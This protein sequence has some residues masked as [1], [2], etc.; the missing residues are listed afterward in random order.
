MGINSLTTWTSLKQNFHANIS[1]NY[2]NYG[3]SFYKHFYLVNGTSYQIGE[4]QDF[5]VNWGFLGK[6]G[7]RGLR[8]GGRGFYQVALDEFGVP[9]GGIYPAANAGARIQ[10]VIT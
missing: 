3:V 6:P 10:S 1:G 5:D 4:I 2:G 7:E 8:G 9:H